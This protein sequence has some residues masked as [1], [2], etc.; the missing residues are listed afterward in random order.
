MTITDQIKANLAEREE[1]LA[2]AELFNISLAEAAKL[3]REG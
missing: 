2:L 1:F 3:Y